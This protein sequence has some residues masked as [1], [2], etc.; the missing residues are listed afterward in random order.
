DREAAGRL[1][2]HKQRLY[3]GY[4]EAGLVRPFPG[5]RLLLDRLA[6]LG[7]EAYL[8]TSGSRASVERVLAACRLPVRGVLTADDV[9]VGKPD[10][11]FYG[12][13]CRRWG[14]RPSS[15]V[16]LEDSAHGVA[17]AVGAGIATLH[18]HTA[19]PAPGAV[20]VRNLDHIVSLLER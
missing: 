6:A 20:A 3:R 11:E 19:D 9:P 2:R 16:A 14:V 4:V 13:A 1:A 12:A 17:S 8:V 5:A 15:A 18:V 7:L 10:P